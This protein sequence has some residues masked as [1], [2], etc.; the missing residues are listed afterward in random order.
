MISVMAG[1][2]PTIHVFDSACPKTWMPG[3]TP[4][5]TKHGS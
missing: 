4:G 5:M 1:L 3:T 2:V